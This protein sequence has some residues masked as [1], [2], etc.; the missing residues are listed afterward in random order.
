MQKNSTHFQ[1]AQG[2]VKGTEPRAVGVC[3]EDGFSVN[4]QSHREDTGLSLIR[5]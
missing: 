4:G 5:K 2:A 3:R 1:V